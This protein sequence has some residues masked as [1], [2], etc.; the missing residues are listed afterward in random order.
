[1]TA[2]IAKTIQ[3]KVAFISKTVQIWVLFS[4][5]FDPK[6]QKDPGPKKDPKK[7]GQK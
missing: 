4:T 1:M 2:Y 3:N 6:R 5:L 7:E